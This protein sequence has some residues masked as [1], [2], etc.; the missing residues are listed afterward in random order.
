MLSPYL[1][2][3]ADQFSYL[4]ITDKGITYH[5]YFLDYSYM[6]ADYPG[7]SNNVYSF[8]IEVM[9]GDADTAVADERIGLTVVEVFRLFF[10]RMEN[11]SVYVC[12]IADERHLA[13][14]RKFDFWFWKYNDGT[15]I[16]EDGVAMVEGKEIL[17]SLLLHRN[18]PKCAE[19][20]FAFKD[21]N[22]RAGDK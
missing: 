8:N 19:I 10:S 5:V 4:F 11:V 12:D 15:I 7:I 22:A 9:D 16:K 1:L 14:K 6:F 3:E 18:N 13:R 20:I 2:Q 21:L 17:N